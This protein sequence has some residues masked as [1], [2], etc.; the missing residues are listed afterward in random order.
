MN[1][2]EE[3]KTI[4]DMKR[5]NKELAIFYMGD[6]NWSISL[7]NPT[8]CVMLGE[9]GGEIEVDG[10]DTLEDAITAMKTEVAQFNADDLGVNSE[11][12]R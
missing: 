9:V 7:G 5:G 6:N 4:I 8:N 12:E 11:V 1:I 10:Y 3:L 2:S